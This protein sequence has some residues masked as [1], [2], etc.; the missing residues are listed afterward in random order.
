[1]KHRLRK[2]PRK[3]KVANV[4]E[5]NSSIGTKMLVVEPT[6]E[7]GKDLVRISV[8]SPWETLDFYLEPKSASLLAYAVK[9]SGEICFARKEKKARKTKKESLNGFINFG[10]GGN[11]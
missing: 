10:V 5:Y 6:G 4:W 8:V 11:G 7:T 9:R 1:M 3:V 2:R